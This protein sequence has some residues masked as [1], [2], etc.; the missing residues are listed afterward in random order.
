[1]QESAYAESQPAPIGAAQRCRHTAGMKNLSV[2]QILYLMALMNFA[3]IGLAIAALCVADREILRMR[4]KA[5]AILTR[6]VT[7]LG[8]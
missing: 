6:L 4:G 8:G 2:E 7:G 3:V 5:R 1:L